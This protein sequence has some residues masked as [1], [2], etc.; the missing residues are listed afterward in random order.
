[1]NNDS[2]FNDPRVLFVEW[3]VLA[4][5]GVLASSG[6][7]CGCVLGEFCEFFRCGRLV[8][9]VDVDDVSLR[10]ILWFEIGK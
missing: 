10:D 7:K 8:L 9:G 5:S 4:F 3:F 6:M 1:M 2:K